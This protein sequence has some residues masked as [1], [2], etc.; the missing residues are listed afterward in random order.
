MNTSHG[1][2][3]SNVGSSKH[4]RMLTEYIQPMMTHAQPP[5]VARGRFICADVEIFHLGQ[6]VDL[7]DRSSNGSVRLLPSS[8]TSILSL[9]TTPRL[10]GDHARAIAEHVGRSEP[11]LIAAVELA[12]D[13]L[14]EAGFLVTESQMAGDPLLAEDDGGIRSIGFVTSDHVPELRRCVAS[15]IENCRMYSPDVEYIVADDSADE[16]VR[17]H[18]R[19]VL[20]DL[21]RPHHIPIRYLGLEEKMEY[22]DLLIR[23]AGLDPALVE[24]ALLPA[25]FPGTTVGANRNWL[26]LHHAGTRFLS[27]DD[28]TVCDLVSPPGPEANICCTHARDVSDIRFFATVDEL[29]ATVEKTSMGLLAF[30]N[31]YLG[32]S[33]SNIV[34]RDTAAGRCLDCKDTSI[35]HAV[36]D[37][38]NR[39]V[40]TMNG[41]HGDCATSDPCWLWLVGPSRR[42]LL[43]S[44]EAYHTAFASRTQLEVKSCPTLAASPFCMSYTLGFDNRLVLPPFLPFDRNSDGLFGAIIRTAFEHAYMAHL[45]IAVAHRPAVER[46]FS[47]DG[48]WA[49]CFIRNL[50]DL[51]IL[52]LA[53]YQHLPAGDESKQLRAL[54]QFLGSFAQLTSKAFQDSMR[55]CVRRQK[56]AFLQKAEEFISREA[57]PDWWVQDARQYLNTVRANLA[58]SGHWIPVSLTSAFATTEAIALVQNTFRMYG[59]LLCR[60]SEFVEAAKALRLRGLLPARLLD[61]D[62]A[63][64]GS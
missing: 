14:V 2:L 16:A 26:L 38:A 59:E 42:R 51:F 61:P 20:G 3:G 1:V 9:C 60:W 44:P 56:A 24:F 31:Q 23:R 6:D 10:L 50:S 36:R 63:A 18:V 47:P 21:S 30:H 48:R 34:R 27:V 58:Q 53:E 22:A 41:L 15:Y 62:R 33:L 19:E 39:V 49:D 4:T 13:Q 54:G 55:R 35:L 57:S 52:I 29:T 45:P 28:D 64:A 43:A 46:R 32:K 37:D 5:P 8:L 11:K 7:V 17:R 25:T 12:L 40:L